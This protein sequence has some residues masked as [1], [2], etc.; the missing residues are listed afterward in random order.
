[1]VREEIGYSNLFYIFL[2]KKSYPNF[3]AHVNVYSF[4]Y[5][6]DAFAC[7][8]MYECVCQYEYN[9]HYHELLVPLGKSNSNCYVFTIFVYS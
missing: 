9:I 3:Y 6:L 1:M 2:C 7:L 8:C 5:A 4:V